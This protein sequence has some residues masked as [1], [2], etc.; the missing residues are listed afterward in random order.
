MRATLVAM[1]LVFACGST[2]RIAQ[3]QALVSSWHPAP[4]VEHSPFA[5]SSSRINAWYAEPLD[6]S[7]LAERFVGGLIL[8]GVAGLAAAERFDNE[9]VVIAYAVGSAAGVLL[10][11]AARESPR[12]VTILLGTAL[13][14]VPLLAIAAA[15]REGPF[16]V[17]ILL[18]GAVTTPI[19]G[20]VGQRW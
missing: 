19:L 12:P 8:G 5:R 16:A 2:V 17:P 14:A 1:A 3:G 9:P 15:E 6:S 11:T 20:A 10:A 18:V 4:R 7:T 13:G